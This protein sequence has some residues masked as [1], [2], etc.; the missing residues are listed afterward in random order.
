MLR[1][2]PN[3]DPLLDAKTHES[4]DPSSIVRAVNVK[5]DVIIAAIVYAF[6]D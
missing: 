2:R 1:Q 5:S 3:H 4:G 6:C